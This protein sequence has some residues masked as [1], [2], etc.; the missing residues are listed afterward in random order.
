MISKSYLEA[1]K[2]LFAHPFKTNSSLFSV[3]WNYLFIPDLIIKLL[4]F[5]CS[6]YK[7]HILDTYLLFYTFL[8][9]A[10]ISCIYF[11]IIYFIVWKKAH[12]YKGDLTWSTLAKLYIVLSLGMSNFGFMIVGGGK[13]FT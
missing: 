9:T 6:N 4:F 1:T 12:I 8:I 7:A 3:F 10:Y 13:Y 2:R 11:P 5:T